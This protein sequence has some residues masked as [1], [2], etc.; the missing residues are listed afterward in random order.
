MNDRLKQ[1]L[2]K[3]LSAEEFPFHKLKQ[4]REVKIADI[5]FAYDNSD[6]IKILKTRGCEIKY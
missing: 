2:A 6:L 1:E 5:F 3:N 4:I